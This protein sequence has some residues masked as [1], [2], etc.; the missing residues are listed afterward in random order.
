MRKTNFV[1]GLLTGLILGILFVLV[2]DWNT[3]GPQLRAKGRVGCTNACCTVA[4]DTTQCWIAWEDG[5]L[6]DTKKMPIG[7]VRNDK[8]QC[9]LHD[10]ESTT[11][12]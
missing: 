8:G 9:E 4:A 5:A 11:K 6:I 7:C 2:I 10:T 3:D 12:P 1:E